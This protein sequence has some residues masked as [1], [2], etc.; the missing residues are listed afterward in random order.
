MA[1]PTE[2][3]VQVNLTGNL[4]PIARAFIKMSDAL[5]ANGH[6]WSSADEALIEE[7]CAAI[8]DAVRGERSPDMDGRAN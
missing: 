8:C 2:I 5:K 1:R 7:A 4:M 3:E 6:I